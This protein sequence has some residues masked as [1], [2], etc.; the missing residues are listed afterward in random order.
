MDFLEKLKQS[1]IVGYERLKKSAV[2][3]FILRN[4]TMILIVAIG[5]SVAVPTIAE[6]RTLSILAA[7]IAWNTLL[8]G[9]VVFGLSHFK[10]AKRLIEGDDGMDFWERALA[11][12]F[13]LGVYFANAIITAGVV[14]GVYMAQL[15]IEAILKATNLG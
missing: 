10:T 15:P 13:V 6:S 1:L 4:S 12:L 2:V 14:I 11:V 3:S 8:T 9:L 7:F 5:L